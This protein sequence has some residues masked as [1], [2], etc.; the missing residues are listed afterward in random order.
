A[1]AGATMIG[2]CCGIGAAHIHT[3]ATAL[4]RAAA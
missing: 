3:V 4:R 2:G 1:D